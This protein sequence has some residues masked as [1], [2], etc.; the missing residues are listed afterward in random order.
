MHTRY[1]SSVNFDILALNLALPHFLLSIVFNGF[2][3]IYLYNTCVHVLYLIS[4][5]INNLSFLKNNIK[6]AY[7][8]KIMRVKQLLLMFC[9]T[10]SNSKL[11][12]CFFF[13]LKF[14]SIINNEFI[15]K[16]TQIKFLGK[17]V[18]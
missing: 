5:I 8:Q 1:F 2:I 3:L 9:V 4:A 13:K 12:D 6:N 14:N 16:F 7:Q 10:Y 15:S 18:F 11:V 17:I